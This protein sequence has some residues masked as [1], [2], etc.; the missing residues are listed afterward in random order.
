M[1]KQ[2]H[3]TLRKRCFFFAGTDKQKGRTQ[4]YRAGRG[5]AEWGARKSFSLKCVC[6]CVAVM[7]Q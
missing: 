5:G 4:K 3:V 6:V 7:F 1:Q 2:Q